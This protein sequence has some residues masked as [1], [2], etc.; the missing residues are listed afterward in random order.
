[1]SRGTA[2]DT[3]ANSTIM[4]SIGVDGAGL[5][6]QAGLGWTMGDLGDEEEEEQD[7]HLDAYFDTM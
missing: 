7:N 6:V 3:D 5:G 4:L 1:M 2:A